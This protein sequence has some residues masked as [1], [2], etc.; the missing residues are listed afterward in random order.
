MNVRFFFGTKAE[1]LSLPVPRNPLGLYFCTDTKELFWADRL[2]T[3]GTRIVPTFA[4]LPSREKAAEGITYFVEETRN[5]Y[6]LSSDRTDWVQV[7]FAP[8]TE[9]S[10]KAISFAGIE[11]EEVDGVFTIDRRCAREALGF[12]VPEGMEDEEFEIASTDYVAN[13][14]SAIEIPEVPTKVSELENDAKYATEQFVADAIV[15]QVPVDEL[16]KKE[17]VL[18]VKTTIKEEVLPKVEKVDEIEPTVSELKTWVENKE[19]LQDIDLEGYATEEF[20]TKKIAEAELADQDVDLSAY[21]TKSETE[22]AIKSAVDAIDVPDVSNLAT[23]EELEA[24]QNVAGSNSVKLMQLD[25]DLVDINAKLETIPSIEGL[26]TET[27]VDEKF[28]AINIPDVSNFITMEEVEAKGYINEVPAEY[29]T[30]NELEA[31]GYLTEHQDL[32]HLAEKDHV[33]AEYAAKEHEHDQ[34]LTEHQDLSEY[35]KKEDLFSGSYNDLTDKPEIPSIEG[36]AT[37]E[38]VNT[39]I[40]N[41]ELPEAELYKVDFNAPDFAAALEAYNNGKLLLLVNAAPDTNGY[42]VMNYVRADLITFTKFLTSRSEAYGSFNTYYLHSDNTWEVSKEVRLNKVEANVSDEVNGE[43]TSIRIGKEVYS[44]PNTD[45]LASTEYVDNAI[46]G[47]EIPE[48]NLT[49]Y[50]KLTDIPDV[51]KFIEEIP[52]EYITED[53]LNAKGYLTEHQDLTDYAKKSDIP[54]TEGLASEAFVEEKIAEKANDIPFTTD[55]FVGKAIGG[56]A[57]GA[58]VKGLTIAEILAKLLELVDEPGENPDEPDE[59]IEPDVPTEFDS[60]AEKIDVAQ[61]PMY[62]VTSEGELVPV[63]FKLVDKDAEPTESG[64]YAVKDSEGNI[65]QAGYQ[66]LTISNDEMYYAVALPKEVDYDTAVTLYSWGPDDKVWVDS[67]MPGFTSDPVEV[68][69]ICGDAGIDISHID[70]N[71]YTVWALEAVCTGSILRYEF[72]EEL[73]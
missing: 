29:I 22:T 73:L 16:A 70:T 44:L 17:E 4:D 65:I 39:A 3:D 55:K 1:Y 62:S 6:V 51:S 24:V 2:L 60:V 13:A 5:G 54:S 58:N 36:L 38:F 68:A 56:F 59:P 48:V 45:G 52:A 63:A 11:L 19:Y 8:A 42:A 27:Y 26:A 43:L 64:F 71:V 12:K 47:I 18:E 33:H 10:V 41:I 21:Y 61:I 20:V 66:D 15:N 40:N 30:E 50:A 69:R 67:E 7:I 72:K 32:S 37:E 9:S 14:I 35:A 34:Y 49:D 53:E 25:S 31:K 28:A 46:A 57:V 23:K